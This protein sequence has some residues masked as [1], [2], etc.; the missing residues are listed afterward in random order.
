MTGKSTKPYA[1]A[2]DDDPIIL[3]DVAVILEEAG[4]RML[5]AMEVAEAKSLLTEHEPSI[6]LLFSD[7]DMGEGEDG[8]A[9][10]RWAAERFD[11][12]EIVIASGACTPS[13]G[14]M[15]D[16]ATFL[17]KP[18][19]AATVKEHLTKTLPDHKKPT[20]LKKAV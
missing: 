5:E 19:N 2:V 6:I 1:L 9:L 20:P 16:R 3:M 4:F 11:E 17:R 8:F 15:P 12:I 7:V 18:F 13:D 14:D 10:A